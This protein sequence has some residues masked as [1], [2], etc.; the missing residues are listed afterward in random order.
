[1]KG[2]TWEREIQAEAPISAEIGADMQ[3]QLDKA[4]GVV[5]V[6]PTELAGPTLLHDDPRIDCL[7]EVM[8]EEDGEMWTIRLGH[9]EPGAI[10]ALGEFSGW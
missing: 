10:D 2:I 6:F 7:L 8:N 1:M 5:G 3:A 9:A 4:R